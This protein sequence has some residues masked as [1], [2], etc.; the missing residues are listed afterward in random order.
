LTDSLND[1]VG[2]KTLILGEVGA[3][4]TRYTKTLLMEARSKG[5]GPITVIDMA[6]QPTKVGDTSVGGFLI[7]VDTEVRVLRCDDI[8]TPRLSAR[9]AKELMELALSNHVE[10]ELLLEE[11]NREPTPVL[12]INDVS[13]YLQ[14]GGLANLWDT[15]NKAETVIVNGYFG[16]KLS[17]DRGTGVSEHERSLMEELASRMDKVIWLH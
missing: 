16:D 4:K 8:K 10:I 2:R 9:N 1:L 3:G 12:F 7:E 13:I 5:L 11:F 15:I 17:D 6:P 14:V